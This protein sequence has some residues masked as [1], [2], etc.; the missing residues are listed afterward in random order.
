MSGTPLITFAVISYQDEKYIREAIEGAFAQTYRPLEIILSNDCSRDRT[1]EIMRSMAAAY[2]GPHSMILNRNGK[3]LGTGGHINRIME[4]SHG[5][6]LVIAAGDDVSFP[7][8]TERLYELFKAGGG[9]IKSLFSNSIL[10]D[11]AGRGD[12]LQFQAP[13]TGDQFPLETIVHGYELGIVAGSSHA[14]TRDVFETF[15]PLVTP[16]SVEDSAIGFRAA[17]IGRIAYTHQPLIKHRRHSHNTW[18]YTVTD[19]PRDL[20]YRAF[21]RE[22]VLRNWIHDIQ[23]CQVLTPEKKKEL[24]GYRTVLSARMAQVRKETDFYR[25]SWFKKA[26]RIIAEMLE[27]MP[28]RKVRHNIGIFLVPAI[29][30]RYVSLKT[31]ARLRQ[32]RYH[33]FRKKT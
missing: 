2:R 5:D 12:K 25:S 28:L 31:R 32:N 20:R 15:G 16:L 27:G 9:E 8:R 26:A 10:I 13:F 22:A 33:L 11:E 3:N 24:E 6:V 17:L 14:W 4:L 7:E 21:E 30:N 29:Y 19:L 1:F 18:Q 23:I